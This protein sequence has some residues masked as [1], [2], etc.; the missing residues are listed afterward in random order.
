MSNDL[1]RS[2]HVDRRP[3]TR[4]KALIVGGGIGGPTASTWHRGP[5]VLIGDAVHA[6]SP[7]AGQ[8]ASLA[9]EDALVVAKCLR[10]IP[11]TGRAF[12][13]CER[14]RRERAE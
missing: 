11:D 7:S 6:V 1:E 8:G 10:D 12:A 14:L 13:A 4:R 9:M 3:T 2:T 5:V